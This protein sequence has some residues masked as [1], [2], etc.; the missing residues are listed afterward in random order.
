[1]RSYLVKIL[2][3]VF[4]PLATNA[5]QNR[6]DSLKAILPNT[7]NDSVRYLIYRDIYDFYEETNRDSAFYYANEYLLL[8][9]KNN[10]KF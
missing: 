4:L 1:M 3:F 9:R 2:L 5:Q 10:K 7:T 6:A 8:A